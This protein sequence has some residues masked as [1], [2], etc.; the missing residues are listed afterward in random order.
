MA[1]LRG[2]IAH[3]TNIV[4]RGMQYAECFRS[5]NGGQEAAVTTLHEGVCIETVPLGSSN[6]GRM[7]CTSC[8]HHDHMNLLFRNKKT[9][10]ASCYST[11]RAWAARP[12]KPGPAQ[13]SWAWAAFF[14]PMGGPRQQK[15]GPTADSGR[16]WVVFLTVFGKAWPESSM[17]RRKTS[18]SNR[19]LIDF[20]GPIVGPD[21]A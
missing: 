20:L 2:L 16:A 15:C 21:Q 1:Q 13:K 7:Y 10:T 3:C 5:H 19:T 8:L 6:L 4:K 11:K 9:R 14:G 17:V 18:H 12:D